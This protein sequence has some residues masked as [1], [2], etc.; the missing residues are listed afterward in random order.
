MRAKWFTVVAALCVG[1]TFSGAADTFGADPEVL[2]NLWKTLKGTNV[3]ESPRVE[4]AAQGYLRFVAPGSGDYFEVSSTTKDNATPESTAREFLNDNAGVFGMA[5]DDVDYLVREKK[6]AKARTYVKLQQTYSGI[7]VFGAY[8]LVQ[9]DENNGIVCVSSDI[10]RDTRSLDSG[11][12]S[13]SPTVSAATARANAAA[14]YKSKHEGTEFTATVPQLVIYRPA[15]VGDIGPTAL[16]W[17]MEVKAVG[18][19][20]IHDVVLVNAESGLIAFKYPLVVQGL[21]RRI[22]DNGAGGILAREEGGA[23]TYNDDVDDTYDYLGDTYDFYSSYHG[24][25]SIDNAGMWL[26]AYVRDPYYTGNAAWTGS[27]MRIGTGMGA[28]DVIAHEYTHGVTQYES[29]LIYWRESGAINEA[30]SDIW[31]E[32]VDLTNGAGTDTP[33][34]RWLMG[35]D[36]VYGYIRDIMYPMTIGHSFPD[37]PVDEDGNWVMPHPLPMPE[38]YKGVGWYYGSYDYGGVHHNMSVVTF[39]AYLLT[40]GED[41]N[42]RSIYGMGLEA[43]AKLFYEVQT[44]LLLPTA[45]HAD[46]AYA[47][48]QAAVNLN[49][50]P[51]DVRNVLHG[52]YA[53]EILEPKYLPLRNFRATSISGGGSVVL[54]WDMQQYYTLPSYSTVTICRRTDRF[55]IHAGDGVVVSNYTGTWYEDTSVVANQEYYYALFPAMGSGNSRQYARVVAGEMHDPLSTGYTRTGSSWSSPIDDLAFKQITYWPQ[56]SIKES[57]YSL[58]QAWYANY[59]DYTA[60]I[61]SDYEFGNALPVPKENHFNL[62]MTDDGFL[63]VPMTVPFPFFGEFY[64]SLLLSSNGFITALSEYR[65]YDEYDDA[66]YGGLPV[67]ENHFAAPRISF[68]FTDL[69]PRSGGEVWARILEDRMVVTFDNVPVFGSL[70]GNTVQCEL[71]YN[72]KIRFTYLNLDFERAVV[73]LSDG[74]GLPWHP[75]DIRNGVLSP[76]ILASEFV[77]LPSSGEFGMLPIPLQYAKAGETVQFLAEGVSSSPVLFYLEDVP[78]A[79]SSNIFEQVDSQTYRFTWSVPTTQVLDS[80]YEFIIRA[81]SA[82]EVVSQKVHIFLTD[83]EVPP[84]ASNLTLYPESPRANQYLTGDYLFSQSQGYT[85][86]GSLLYW[87]KNNGLV[88][89]L[90]GFKLVPPNATKVGDTWF[91]TITPAILLGFDYYTTMPIYL[92]GQTVQ[93]PSRTI[94]ED[95]LPD[96]NKDGKVNSVDVQ[97]VVNGVLGFSTDKGTDVDGDGDTTAMDVQYVLNATF[98]KN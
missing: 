71:F 25:D 85:E 40:D 20:P 2:R 65:T 69:D 84:I 74:R 45:D 4:E 26:D 22:F 39:L 32:Y 18:D 82:G 59:Q 7:P 23:L 64:D 43:V 72:G 8:A 36:T 49:L 61:L 86:S 92:Y 62:A 17:K 41:Y 88:T 89:P 1:V 34:V 16:A 35:E 29:E 63:E 11:A 98:V 77:D 10:M 73:G 83:T 52:L 33:S 27:R 70:Y 38:T 50:D 3:V 96:T 21:Y 28:D 37:H 87:F 48:Q 58:Q 53:V 80:S 97:H 67:L 93:S 13:V 57:E 47:L 78:S 56:F 6:G 24:R 31:G 15:V 55:P 75:S 60:T 42:S 90:T 12:V 5:S 95:I 54:T 81:F 44:N 94:V 19:E 79:L 91:F 30:F 66:L 51:S 9:L 68:L 14:A 46:F 76:R